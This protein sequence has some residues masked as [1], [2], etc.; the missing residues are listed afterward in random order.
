MERQ[1]VEKFAGWKVRRSKIRHRK[2]VADGEYQHKFVRVVGSGGW[3]T[4]GFPRNYEHGMVSNCPRRSAAVGK[5]SQGQ[6]RCKKVVTD[7][8]RSEGQRDQ[9]RYKT[10]KRLLAS[11]GLGLREPRGE[12]TKVR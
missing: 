4:Q 2:E 6:C 8:E 1:E 5:I 12:L 3:K 11:P 7:R 10:S 9:E